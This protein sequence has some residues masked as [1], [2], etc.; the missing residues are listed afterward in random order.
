MQV[1]S[2]RF[3]CAI[4]LVQVGSCKFSCV[5]R[6]AILPEEPFT[7]LS[8]KKHKKKQLHTTGVPPFHRE[9]TGLQTTRNSREDEEEEVIQDGMC[10][11]RQ[12]TM[13]VQAM[14]SFTRICWRRCALACATMESCCRPSVLAPRAIDSVP[15]VC[16]CTEKRGYPPKKD[17][18]THDLLLLGWVRGFLGV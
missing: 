2:C 8:G 6:L 3:G 12:K 7:M 11:P 18:H 10:S 17:A 5:I 13:R 15:Q 9:T 4:R 1:G 16:G 14:A